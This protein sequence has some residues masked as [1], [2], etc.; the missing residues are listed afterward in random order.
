MIECVWKDERNRVVV[1]SDKGETCYDIPILTLFERWHKPALTTYQ[2]RK[3]AVAKAFGILRC[4][5][6]VVDADTALATLEGPRGA[7]SRFVNVRALELIDHT[8]ETT[9]FVF[10]SGNVWSTKT[11]AGLARR[12]EDA[13][14][15]ADH[16]YGG[17]VN[18]KMLSWCRKRKRNR[19][20][21]DANLV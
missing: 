15:V 12:L 16:L 21:S 9:T 7:A 1:V 20:N 11:P 17:G 18:K 10:R 4:Q 5:P 6:V 8:E 3:K 2:G 14:R 13:M 19:G